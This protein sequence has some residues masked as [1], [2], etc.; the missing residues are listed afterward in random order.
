M[1]VKHIRVI[2]GE[3][4]RTTT[5]TTGTSESRELNGDQCIES[6]SY[7]GVSD[8]KRRRSNGSR[9]RYLKWDT[10]AVTCRSWW[11]SRRAY[12][13][14]WRG[15]KRRR[16]RRRKKR[17]AF[18][19]RIDPPIEKA[20][21]SDERDRSSLRVN[22]MIIS[23]SKIFPESRRLRLAGNI[24]VIECNALSVE[25]TLSLELEGSGCTAVVQFLI[26]CSEINHCTKMLL[27][28]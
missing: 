8:I 23:Q 16:R 26:W 4:T 1:I 27:M 9:Y 20:I 18:A 15:W 14:H 21:W 28:D 24:E 2:N 3:T 10:C 6:V 11:E 25:K 22:K 7:V 17:S 13:L 19:R 5:T 12:P